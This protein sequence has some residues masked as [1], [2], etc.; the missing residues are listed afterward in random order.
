MFCTRCG[1]VVDNKNKFCSSCGLRIEN[2]D[3][4]KNTSTKKE[5]K[6]Q[7]ED[8][9]PIS[10]AESYL[11]LTDI[12]D[13]VTAKKYLNKLNSLF[14]LT[15]VGIILLNFNPLFFVI[16][17]PLLIYFVVFC[18][19]VIKEERVSNASAVFV[20]LFAPISWVWFYPSIMDPLK[21]I[22]GEK[23]L[24]KKLPKII[25]DSTYNKKIRTVFWTFIGI[26]VIFLGFLVIYA[27][28]LNE[29][30]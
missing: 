24:P 29:K 3:N 16:L 12:R 17:I 4:N 23:E 22:V 13:V 28:I 15:F 8:S 1:S 9:S 27:T 7:I 2:F 19:K 6:V 21:I 11:A 20:F 25:E 18:N 14:F 30:H 26:V 5:D 10:T